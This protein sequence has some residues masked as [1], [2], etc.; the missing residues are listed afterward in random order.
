MTVKRNKE[1][2]EVFLYCAPERF[3]S[4]HA[5]GV[6]LEM[7]V[8]VSPLLCFTFVQKRLLLNECHVMYRCS[9]SPGEEFQ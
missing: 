3:L 9:W 5:R 2:K 6:V 7:V 4:T 1:K 8:S